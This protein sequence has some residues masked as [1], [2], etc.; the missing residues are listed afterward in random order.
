MDTNIITFDDCD[1]TLIKKIETQEKTANQLV[2]TGEMVL[3]ELS[4]IFHEPQNE[5][6]HLQ[7]HESKEK[8]IHYNIF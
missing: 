4:K 2:E 3:R 5:G 1:K 7:S 6:A 8:K